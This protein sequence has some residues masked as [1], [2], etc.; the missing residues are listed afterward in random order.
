MDGGSEKGGQPAYPPAA[1]LKLYLYGYMNKI[2]S[3]RML[4]RE[5]KRNLE[6][7]WLIQGFQ[8]S[9]ASIANFRKNNIKAVNRDFVQVCRELGL[10]GNKEVGIDGTFV[11]GNACKDS[12][13]TQEKQLE[14]LNKTI[15]DYVEQLEENDNSELDIS[16]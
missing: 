1:M 7:I 16:T 6:V 12:I 4:E 11:H 14:K 2:R 9:H 10:Y 15:D 8:P 3:S 5:A 13:H